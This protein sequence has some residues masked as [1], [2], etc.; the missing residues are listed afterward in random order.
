MTSPR[1]V[2]WASLD[3]EA[4]RVRAAPPAQFFCADPGR[5]VDYVAQSGPI[6]FDYSRQKVDR[7]VLRRLFSLADACDLR[8][9]IAGMF[10]GRV[11][12][13][14][15]S[16]PA[17]HVAV[18]QPR[19][20]GLGGAA[21]EAEVLSERDRMLDFAERVRSGSVKGSAS[22]PFRDVVNIGIGGSDL[23]PAMAVEA[24]RAFSRNAPRV[25]FASNVDGCGLHDVLANCDPATTLFIVA[26]K[27]FTTQETMANART[28]RD[29]VAARIGEAGVP[30]HFAAVSVNASAM[31]AFGVHPE[32]RFRMWDWV[33]GRYSLWSSIGVSLA[34]A[35]G[36][37]G[38]L[39]LL[40][41]AH[42]MDLEF[43]DR[44][45][46]L[47][48]C[49]GYGRPARSNTAGCRQARGGSRGG[50]GTL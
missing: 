46:S 42:A 39:E 48:P 15:E 33:G 36:R 24:L 29:W 19:G 35:I 9:E 22:R 43:R 14:T 40:D 23:G 5:F 16:R 41:G 44:K 2:A 32:Y 12:N 25:H 20:G 13:G 10:A 6:R 45:L 17:L 37:D 50:H 27:T 3:A 34:V 7:D 47:R 28:A 18:R 4:G 26:S 11:V 30:A 21:V 1:E 49:R 31:D 38:F 8:G